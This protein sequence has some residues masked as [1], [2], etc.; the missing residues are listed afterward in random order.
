MEILEE[1]NSKTSSDFA[2]IAIVVPISHQICWREAA[3]SLNE[4]YKNMRKKYGSG[5][6]GAVARHGR[7]IIIDDSSANA[8]KRRLESPIMLAEQLQS[9]I[10]API[11]LN[12]SIVGVLLVGSRNNRIYNEQDIQ[13]ITNLAGEIALLLDEE[14]SKK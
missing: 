10:A 13:T 4:K 6:V 11:L 12:N 9:A 8:E 2:A 14:N 5:L 1:L 3:G 7:I